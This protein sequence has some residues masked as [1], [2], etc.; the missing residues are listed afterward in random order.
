MALGLVL[1]GA[2]APASAA[3]PGQPP[4]LARHPHH[5]ACAAPL[6]HHAACH[7]EVRDDVAVPNLSPAVLPAGYGPADLQAAYQLPSSTAGLGQTVAVIGAFDA[8]TIEADL[9]VYRARYG[10]PACTTVNGCFHKVNQDGNDLPL[11]G[12][13]SGWGQ[14]MSLDTEMVSA[15]CPRC[16]ILLVEANND[17]LSGLGTS[18][19]TAV[20][21][22]AKFVSNSYGG[23]VSI[24]DAAATTDYY[25]HPGV[26]VTASS[27][28]SGY[29][30]QYP[31]AS[32]AVVAVGGTSL[33]RSSSPRGWTETVWSG[34]GSGCSGYDAKPAWQKDTGCHTRAIADVAAVADPET[35][36]AVYDSTP[37]PISRQ[38]GWMIF[39]GT[40][41]AAPLIAATYALAGTPARDISAASLLYHQPNE[42]FDVFAG[43]NGACAAS[44]LCTAAPGY[45]GPTGI[46]SPHGVAAFSPASAAQPPAARD[47]DGDGHNDV[48]ARDAAGNLW[49]YPGN[50]GGGWLARRRVGTGWNGFSPIT[51]P[52]DFNGDGHPDVLARDGAGRLWL[53]PG[54]GTA[55][56]LAPRIVGSG[57]NGY[58]AFTAPGDFNGDGHRDLLAR[59][60]AGDLWLY[61]GNGRGGWL[62]RA[63]VGTSWGRYSAVLGPGDFDGDGHADV[64]ARDGVGDLW[65][66]PG[67]GSGGALDRARVGTSWNGF[68]AIT[69][70]G[71]LNG[72][73]HPDLL[74]RDSAGNLW[75][76]PGNGTGGW[77]TRSQV[78]NGWNGLTITP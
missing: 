40:S 20:A 54:N 30:A 8:P 42:L 69:A 5:R 27:G 70:P 62:P 41:A 7:A 4:G 37:D 34:A 14:E 45:D 16:H 25:A 76:Y 65:L 72:D 44:Y 63:R 35:G 21:L 24:N 53:Y 11:P 38:A 32:P 28:D 3:P 56:W 71:D 50:G 36:V 57:W 49:L 31:A 18:V 75:L 9:N 17:S 78:G 19:N 2:S 23:S 73:G 39:G 66:H 46:G 59:D 61:P 51:A 55:G 58:S 26:V 22:G 48:L 6:P 43:A 68:S 47:F 13:D 33:T 1:A 12:M 74:A 77:L 52:G 64:L 10:L 15:A 29:G 67:N 60:S